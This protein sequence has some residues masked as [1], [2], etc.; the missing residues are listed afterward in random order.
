MQN[1]SLA[2]WVWW[3]I[4]GTLALRRYSRRI[5]GSRLSTPNRTVCSRPAWA[6]WDSVSEG[7]KN[8]FSKNLNSLLRVWPRN[9]MVHM[10]RRR[11]CIPVCFM[12]KLFWK[13]PVWSGK[14]SVIHDSWR[15]AK[16]LWPGL[17]SVFMKEL[18]WP[19]LH[20]VF[21]KELLGSSSLLTQF[22]CTHKI[23]LGHRECH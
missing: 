5:S 22:D 20:E 13:S 11:Q 17:H 10:W 3:L 7:R 6:I 8:P 1:E 4:P 15:K 12:R 18:L 16:L 19:G 14:M 2:S 9:G 23:V 21:T